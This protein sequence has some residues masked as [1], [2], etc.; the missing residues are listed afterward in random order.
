MTRGETTD[1]RP[2]PLGLGKNFYPRRKDQKGNPCGQTT[3]PAAGKPS[4]PDLPCQKRYS[5]YHLEIGKK[6][7]LGVR[8]AW[9]RGKCRKNKRN[10]GDPAF[11]KGALG[12]PLRG[13]KKAR[14]LIR[15]QTARNGRKVHGDNSTMIGE[16][17][18]KREAR[19]T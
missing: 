6:D 5:T 15:P 1:F 3:F 16:K 10:G 9:T 19:Q 2:L 17:K 18:G 8:G 4:L 13:Q 14:A 12:F 7:V 11:K